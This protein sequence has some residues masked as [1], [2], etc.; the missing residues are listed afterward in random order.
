M[1]SLIYGS[2]GPVTGKVGNL[3]VSSWKRMPYVKSLPRDRKSPPTEK[4]LINRQNGLW[5]RPGSDQ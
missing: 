1:A 5:R 4:E 2:L 3:I